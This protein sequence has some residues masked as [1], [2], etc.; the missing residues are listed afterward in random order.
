MKALTGPR[1]GQPG[2]RKTIDMTKMTPAEQRVQQVKENREFLG[3]HYAGSE[4]EKA[5]LK[6]A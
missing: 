2:Y 4:R 5:D 3:K 1:P 6:L